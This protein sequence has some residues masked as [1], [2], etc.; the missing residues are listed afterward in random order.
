MKASFFCQPNKTVKWVNLARGFLWTS[1]LCLRGKFGV[2]SV[3]SFLKSHDFF[4]LK[5][6]CLSFSISANQGQWIDFVSTLKHYLSG[7][8]ANSWRPLRSP[9]HPQHKF[10]DTLLGVGHPKKWALWSVNG[11]LT[12]S[13]SCSHLRYLRVSINKVSAMPRYTH[14]C[15]HLQK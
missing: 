7:I 5:F 3:W 2:V 13:C 10:L 14:T 15:E 12:L 6:V 8:F 4:P 9:P 1:V 11:S